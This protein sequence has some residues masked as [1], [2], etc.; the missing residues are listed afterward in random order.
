MIFSSKKRILGGLEGGTRGGL[1]DWEEKEKEKERML[2]D[3]ERGGDERAGVC[4][5]LSCLPSP[6][7][8]GYALLLA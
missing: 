6:P 1:G 2:A 8:V 7:S 5:S 3:G 4:L